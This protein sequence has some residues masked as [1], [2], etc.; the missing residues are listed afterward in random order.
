LV[1]WLNVWKRD[2]YRPTNANKQVRLKDIIRGSQMTHRPKDKTVCI[3]GLGYVGLPLA[4]T[5]ILPDWSTGIVS[6]TVFDQT[7]V[8]SLRVRNALR[9]GFSYSSARRGLQFLVAKQRQRQCGVVGAGVGFKRNE[10]Q[11]GIT[12]GGVR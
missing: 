2:G 11:D 9:A 1:E 4:S 6:L 12:I 8:K 7:F 5:G 10:S 3:A